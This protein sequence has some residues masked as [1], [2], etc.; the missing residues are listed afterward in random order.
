MQNLQPLKILASKSIPRIGRRTENSVK[1]NDNGWMPKIYQE[2]VK[3][4]FYDQYFKG[5]E[6]PG[7]SD[8]E[9]INQDI[10]GAFQPDESYPESGTMP[11]SESYWKR[12]KK[13]EQSIE[14]HSD[15]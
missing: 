3:K 6:R 14:E 9:K 4:N 10:P 13:G 15:V 1:D 7:W 12:I 2:L 11:S 5:T 8:L